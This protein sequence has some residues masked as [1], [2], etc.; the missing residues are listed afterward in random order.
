[1]AMLLRTVMSRR[2]VQVAPRALVA[3]RHMSAAADT[4]TEFSQ[5]PWLAELGLEER[6]HGVFDGEWRGSGPEV[7]SINPATGNVIGYV[8]EVLP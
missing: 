2:A 5:H 8:T 7:A 3:H 1:M 6:N 4:K